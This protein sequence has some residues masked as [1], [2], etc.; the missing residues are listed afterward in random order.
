MD[1][2]H[3]IGGVLLSV[4][5]TLNAHALEIHESEQSS[6]IGVS[7]ELGAENVTVT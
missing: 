3:A 2:V 1:T 6:K 4:C 5:I 7:L